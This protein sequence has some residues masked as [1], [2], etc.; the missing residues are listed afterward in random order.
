MICCEQ[1]SASV[2]G[3]CRG[4]EGAI[5]TETGTGGCGSLAD[6]RAEPTFR[7][8]VEAIPA[9]VYVADADRAGTR[10]VSPWLE[11][12]T[13]QAPQDW[14]GHPQGW[15]RTVHPDDRDGVLS[16]LAS[17]AQ[18]GEPFAGGCETKRC[19]IS[20]TAPGTDGS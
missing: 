13:G 15:L 17:S 19:S 11:S 7:S 14:T 6:E 3:A 10:Y 18:R 1:L 9:V 20:P 5:M 4:K 8:L 12:L 16:L 2:P